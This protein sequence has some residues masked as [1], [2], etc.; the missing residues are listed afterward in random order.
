MNVL[1]SNIK[2]LR[3]SRGMTQQNLAEVVVANNY[4]TITKCESGNNVPQ[5]KDLITLSRFCNVSVDS[6]LGI[7][8]KVKSA[9]TTNAY[10]YIP[11]SISAG[12][13]IVAEPVAEYDAEKINIPD[14]MMGKYAGDKNIYITKVN[15]ESM[16]LVI[17]DQSLIA[18]KP[19]ELSELKNGDIV[20]YNYDGEYAVKRFFRQNDKVIFRPDSN[21]LSFTDLVI[22]NN[23]LDLKIKGKVVLYIVEL[24]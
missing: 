12:T 15:G 1:G 17:P 5:G 18:V 6:I 7:D 20:I 8:D 4:T 19:V 14:S 24:D 16:N 22:D 23:E 11:T 10:K 9:V 3:N 2:R 21:D 13:P